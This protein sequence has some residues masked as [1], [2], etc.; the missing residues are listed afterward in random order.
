MSQVSIVQM[1]AHCDFYF[2]RYTNT[3]TYKG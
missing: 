1:Y 2:L 3:L